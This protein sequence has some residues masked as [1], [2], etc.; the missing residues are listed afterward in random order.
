MEFHRNRLT[1]IHEQEMTEQ[2]L[3]AAVDDAA[4]RLNKAIN[5][6]RDHP[7]IGKTELRSAVAAGFAEIRTYID[8]AT[9]GSYLSV[10][11][12]MQ[13]DKV[14]DSI[15]ALLD[16]K[17]GAPYP[18]D[19]LR[20]LEAE[21]R[22]RFKQQIPPG[23]EDAKKDENRDCGD[24]I[25]WR[26]LIDEAIRRKIPVLFVTN[27]QKDD[28]YRRIHGLTTGPRLE[29]INEM[30]READ[31]DFHL[32]T[33]ALFLDTAPAFLRTP[34]LKEATVTEVSRLDE[35]NQASS[36]ADTASDMAVRKLTAA[37]SSSNG[38]Q[39]AIRTQGGGEDVEVQITRLQARRTELQKRLTE[40]ESEIHLYHAADTAHQRSDPR[41]YSRALQARIEATTDLLEEATRR[42]ADLRGPNVGSLQE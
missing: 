33:L 37:G 29:L 1:V 23:Y 9:S 2:K 28:W 30:K 3:R 10:K 6:F 15:T 17:V 12:A 8:T 39:S 14:L 38:Q 13:S 18:D 19:R 4:D 31:V 21:A 34:P 36:M 16:G 5:G 27:D 32:Q 22:E 11:A 35:L 26:Q 41:S 24:Y 25:L 20:D 40:L 42:L 7:A